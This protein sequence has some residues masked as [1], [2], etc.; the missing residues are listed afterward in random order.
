ME[1]FKDKAMQ[2]H[3]SETHFNFMLTILMPLLE[4][5]YMKVP[6]GKC[7]M[8]KYDFLF[9]FEETYIFK[10]LM[11]NMQELENGTAKIPDKNAQLIIDWVKK[12][13]HWIRKEKVIDE[14]G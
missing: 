6:E 10:R 14:K 9:R 1:D 13:K 12:S 4:R 5:Y 11:R 2:T 8:E 3:A 7:K